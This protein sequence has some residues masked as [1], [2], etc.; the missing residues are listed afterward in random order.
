MYNLIEYSNNY[1]KTK[2]SL[3]QYYRDESALTDAGSLDDFPGNTASFKLKQKITGSTENGGTKAVQ[4][5]IPLKHLNNFLKTLEI[6]LINCKIN[7]ILTWSTNCVISN[8][9]ANQDTIFAT[10]DTKKLFQL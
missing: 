9:A 7:L 3:R 6:P 1:S 4:I 10:T 2:G 5:V 8:A